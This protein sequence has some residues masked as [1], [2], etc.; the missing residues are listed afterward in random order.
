MELAEFGIRVNSLS[1]TGT[2]PAEGIERAAAW[3]VGWEQ[4]LTAPRRAPT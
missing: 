1:P 2:D 3:G 4:A